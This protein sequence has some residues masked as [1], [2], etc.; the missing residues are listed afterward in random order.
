LWDAERSQ[1]RR[2]NPG[3]PRSSWRASSPG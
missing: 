1:R 3:R 2:D